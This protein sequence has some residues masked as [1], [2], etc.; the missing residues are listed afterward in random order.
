[1]KRNYIIHIVIGLLLAVVTSC[2]VHEWPAPEEV[3]PFR[4]K[5]SILNL[6]W[7]MMT[8]EDG[9]D[10]GG[11]ATATQTSQRTPRRNY[12]HVIILLAIVCLCVLFGATD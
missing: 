12:I 3:V 11:D 1:M 4:I 5:F 6:K 9:D 8:H 7:E 10:S 2:A